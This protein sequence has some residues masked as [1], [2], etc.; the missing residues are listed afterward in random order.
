MWR[1]PSAQDQWVTAIEQWSAWMRAAGD[2]ASTIS[3]RRYQVMRFAELHLDTSPWKITTSQLASWLGEYRW[4]AETRRSYRAAVRSFYTWAHTMELVKKNPTA[5]LPRVRAPKAPA[6]PT[7]THVLEAAL[8]AASDRDRLI[9]LCAAYAGM[10]RAEIAAMRWDWIEHDQLR[11]LGKGNKIRVVPLSAAKPLRGELE[12]ER[13]RRAAGGHGTGYRYELGLDEYVFPGQHGTGGMHPDA[14]GK[15]GT[16]ALGSTGWT[17]HTLRHRF[18]TRAYA[19][20]RDLLAVQELLGHSSLDTT[21]R[22]TQ[23]PDG[24]LSDAVNAV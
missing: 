12:A 13:A 10:R 18:A 20:T 7:P 3:K 8:A 4:K 17:L 1:R 2:A 14:I 23:T 15:V 24:A 6:R 22:Y 11:I 19:G 5:Q 9:L 16:K 21:R